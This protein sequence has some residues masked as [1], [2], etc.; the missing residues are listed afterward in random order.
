VQVGDT[1]GVTGVG[2]TGVGLAGGGVTGGAAAV[3][4]SCFSSDTG[5]TTL[6]T[7]WRTLPATDRQE[8][9]ERPAASRSRDTIIRWHLRSILSWPPAA[10]V[11]DADGRPSIPGAAVFNLS[12]SGRLALIATA[13][14]GPLG[15]DVEQLRRLPGARAVVTRRFTDHEQSAVLT[16][17][18]VDEAFLRVWTIKEAVAKAQ[19]SGLRGA[20]G[21]AI[22][23]PLGPSPRLLSPGPPVAIHPC[24]PEFAHRHLLQATVAATP[25]ATVTWRWVPPPHAG[26]PSPKT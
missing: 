16:A 17:P 13:D 24:P 3:T 23:D 14:A 21:V 4:A 1:T 2:V 5:A 12:H 8:L 20:L 15:A 9:L 19:G 25:G 10:L 7:C 18:E 26:M 11:R 6:E 22:D